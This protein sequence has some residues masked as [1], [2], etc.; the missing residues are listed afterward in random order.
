MKELLEGAL[1]LER[2]SCS[3]DKSTAP[4]YQNRRNSGEKT[5]AK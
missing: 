1:S 4:D 3:D 2:P 5:K